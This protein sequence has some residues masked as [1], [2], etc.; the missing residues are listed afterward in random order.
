MKM[1]SFLLT[2]IES[3][4]PP[5]RYDTFFGTP[6]TLLEVGKPFEMHHQLGADF[7]I[8]RS[9]RTSKVVDIIS[10]DVNSDIGKIVTTF[11]TQNSTYK[12]VACKNKKL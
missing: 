7:G 6:M 9:I 2:K 11:T 12:L 4:N 8:N 10:I 3:T 1:Y 5:S